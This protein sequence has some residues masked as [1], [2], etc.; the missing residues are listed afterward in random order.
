MQFLCFYMGF[1]FSDRVALSRYRHVRFPPK[2][3]IKYNLDIF[4][5][6]CII[7]IVLFYRATAVIGRVIMDTDV[8]HI[9]VAGSRILN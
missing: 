5:G 4:R 9:R 1:P 2:I 6:L 8:G 3:K 7:H